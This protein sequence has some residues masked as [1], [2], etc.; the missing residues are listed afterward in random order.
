MAAQGPFDWQARLERDGRVEFGSR[1]FAWLTGSRQLTVTH[2]GVRLGGGPEVD[3]DRIVAVSTSRGRLTVHYLPLPDDRMNRIE[4]RSGQ[5]R[6]VL[7]LPRWGSVRADDL[8][9]WL[10]KVKGGPMAEVDSKL[11]GAG[12]ARVYQLRRDP[13]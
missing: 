2:E 1:Y 13:T 7:V 6:L 11:G 5:K 9:V 3:L 4:R 10:L 12:V 8:A